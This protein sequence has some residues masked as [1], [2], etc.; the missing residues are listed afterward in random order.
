MAEVSETTAEAPDTRGTS[1]RFAD[2][3]FAVGFV[4]LAVLLI[5]TLAI[6]AAFALGPRTVTERCIARGIIPFVPETATSPQSGNAGSP[7]MCHILEGILS[8]AQTAVL[9]FA[10]VA[11]LL[12]VIAGLATYRRMETR[13]RRNRVVVGAVFGIQASVL[14]AFLLWFIR[15]T[16]EKSI[17]QFLN[18]EALKVDHTFLLRGLVITLFMALA[19]ESLGIVLGVLLSLL[20]IS[21]RTA[22]RAPARVYINIFR[23]T[24][25]LVQLSIGYFGVN[26]G[27][28][29]HQSVF[30]VAIVVMGLNAGAYTAEVFRAGIQSIEQGQMEAARSLGFSYLQ[31]MRYSIVP[32][33]LRRVIPPLLNEFVILIKDTSLVVI[34][35]LPLQRLELFGAGQ[36]GYSDT[37][38]ATYFVAIAI[39]YLIITLPMIGIVNAVERRLRS[40]LVSVTGAA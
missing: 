15:A 32:Q 34:L 12:A 25:L 40:G 30:V 1:S 10:I 28:Q 2:G 6:Q 18:V 23:G 21:K 4:S 8:P 14:G 24:P 29:L 39:G 33:A 13:R 11:G 17:T 3:V 37:Y 19:A 7:G 35:G 20:T 22:V 9:L 16:P 26:N 38:N 36:Q 5:G 31:A 27:L